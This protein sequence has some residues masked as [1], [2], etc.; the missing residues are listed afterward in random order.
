MAREGENH[1]VCSCVCV[2]LFRL[3][4]VDDLDFI[5]AFIVIVIS[6]EELTTSSLL[7]PYL[8]VLG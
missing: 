4:F 7:A 2:C 5:V 3:F 8:S 6:N 1:V